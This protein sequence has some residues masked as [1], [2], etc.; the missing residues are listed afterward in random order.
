MP[1]L[2][3]EFE[4]LFQFHD[5]LF[6]ESVTLPHHCLDCILRRSL[7]LTGERILR[8]YTTLL[9]LFGCRFQRHTPNV[10][11][12]HAAATANNTIKATPTDRST[13]VLLL[14]A[15]STATVQMKNSP[16]APTV[17]IFSNIMSPV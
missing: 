5:E 9:F 4:L 12:P 14:Q 1:V 6:P 16:I 10:L 13:A 3:V 7:C 2:S 17:K 11:S 15:W 8:N